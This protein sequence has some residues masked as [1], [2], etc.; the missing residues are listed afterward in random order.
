[1]RQKHE[2]GRVTPYVKI[3]FGVRN[4]SLLNEAASMIA[5]GGGMDYRLNK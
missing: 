2:S 1:M 5:Y 4:G 3:L